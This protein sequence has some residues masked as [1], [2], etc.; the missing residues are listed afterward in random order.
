MSPFEGWKVVRSLCGKYSDGFPCG[1]I[2]CRPEDLEKISNGISQPIVED[3]NDRKEFKTLME[4]AE[5]VLWM[6]ENEGTKE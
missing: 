6:E 4:H 2:L 5:M 3:Y 1:E